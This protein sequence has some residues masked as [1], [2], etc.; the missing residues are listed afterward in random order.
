MTPE[1]MR[2]AERLAQYAKER[3]IYCSELARSNTQVVAEKIARALEAKDD[4]AKAEIKHIHAA[5][6]AHCEIMEAEIKK[7]QDAQND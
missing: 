2:I 6:H 5:H 1:N 7:L 3:F 4:A